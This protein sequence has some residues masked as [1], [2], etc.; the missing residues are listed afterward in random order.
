M[1]RRR[2]LVASSKHDAANYGKVVQHLA[3]ANC[4]VLLFE[5]DSIADGSRSFALHVKPNGQF[6]MEYD[7]QPFDP[8]T[9][10]AAWHRRA[11]YFGEHHDPLRWLSLKDEY[12][13]LMKAVATFIPADRWLNTA[14]AMTVAGRKLPQLIR[15]GEHGFC[16][17]ETVVSNAWQSVESLESEKVI[18]KLTELAV[19]YPKDKRKTLPTTVIPKSSLPNHAV[20]Y[21]GIWQPYHEK[22]KEWRVTVVGDAVFGVAIYTDSEAKDDWR[23]HQEKPTVRFEAEEF[24]REWADKCISF[25]RT[26]GLHYGAYD[27]IEEPDGRMVFLEVNPNGQF[28]WLEDK[29]GLPISKAIADELMAIAEAH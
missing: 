20:P 22:K 5:P 2:I 15:A 11:N 8:A 1:K 14:D 21:P 7:G 10:D 16:V 9:V 29:L 18:V 13:S 26:L 6:S 19:L 25:L 28:M 24:P 12:T 4:E 3:E 23:V 27:F 17:P